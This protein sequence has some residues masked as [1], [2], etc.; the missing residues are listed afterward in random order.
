VGF[1]FRVVHTAI[2][3]N[4]LGG[5]MQLTP[6][7]RAYQQSGLAGLTPL[8]LP[9]VSGTGFPV[10]VPFADSVRAYGACDIDAGKHTKAPL[11]EQPEET[12]REL[13][14]P[15]HALGRFARDRGSPQTQCEMERSTDSVTTDSCETRVVVYRFGNAGKPA[16]IS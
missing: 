1:Q 11:V 16:G 6:A 14:G 7:H 15:G 12:V 5:V 4:A 13:I 8:Q 2:R 9:K 3:G 10:E